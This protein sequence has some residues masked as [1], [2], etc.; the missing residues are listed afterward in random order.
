MRAPAFSG[1]CG[2]AIT[3]L[4]CL[5]VSLSRTK[6][7][8]ALSAILG[9]VRDPVKRIESTVC[10][11]VVRQSFYHYECVKRGALFLSQLLVNAR[12]SSRLL[13]ANV[14]CTHYAPKRTV[15]QSAGFK[16]RCKMSFATDL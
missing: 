16:N 15:S 3:L 13:Y 11:L 14:P 5:C 6:A 1:Q 7:E 10:F 12:V 8:Q 2:R 9:V 4:I